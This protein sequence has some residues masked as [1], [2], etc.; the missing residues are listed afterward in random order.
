MKILVVGGGGREHALA[1][2]FAQSPRV[3]EILVAPGNAGT[4]RESKTR[5]VAVAAGDLGGLLRL[6]QSELVDLTVIGPEQPLVDGVVDRFEAAGARCFG[7]RAGA[8]RL[9]G[10]KA[11]AK[12]FLAR[13]NIQRQP[14][15][16]SMS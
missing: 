9:E 6:A 16:P 2:K 10:S 3:S 11:F 1:W 15:R 8:A 4:A 12:A 7:P 14:M 5:N 13:H